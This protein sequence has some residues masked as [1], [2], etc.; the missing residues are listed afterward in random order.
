MVKVIVIAS[1][2]VLGL[3]AGYFLAIANSALRT[4]FVGQHS[5]KKGFDRVVENFARL[6]GYEAVAANCNGTSDMQRVLSMEEGVIHDLQE[7][8]AVDRMLINTAEAKLLARREIVEK[9]SQMGATNDRKAKI[10]DLLKN[11][12]WIDPSDTGMREIIGFLDRDQCKQINIG[13]AR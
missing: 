1:C 2:L 13:G 8:G 10:E 5:Q 3:A 9:D 11:E 4:P 7:H 12:G 6:G